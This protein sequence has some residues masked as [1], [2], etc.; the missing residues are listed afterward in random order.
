LESVSDGRFRWAHHHLLI[1]FHRLAQ[2]LCSQFACLWHTFQ[3]I[4]HVFGFSMLHA[5]VKNC[6]HPCLQS[7]FL[8]SQ[9]G[10]SHPQLLAELYVTLSRH[11]APRDC[12]HCHHILS[13]PRAPPI[14]WLALVPLSL[15]PLRSK[16]ITASS[17]LLRVAPPLDTVSILSASPLWLVP[18]S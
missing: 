5:I 13:I 18:F 9:P 7:R 17:S 12:E 16:A 15:P 1:S 14:R 2:I 4:I 10:E 11:T 6:F 3:S 8:E